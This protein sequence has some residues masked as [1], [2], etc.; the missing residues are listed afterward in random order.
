MAGARGLGSLGAEHHG[1]R[2]PPGIE[3]R[4]F[5]T[6]GPVG[7]DTWKRAEGVAG[8][9]QGTADRAAARGRAD[10]ASSRRGRAG[11]CS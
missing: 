8:Q 7:S 11:A 9:E 1:G 6:P 10:S 4:S 5:A 2:I 3:G